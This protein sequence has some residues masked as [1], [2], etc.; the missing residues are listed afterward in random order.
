MPMC[1]IKQNVQKN[2]THKNWVCLNSGY[3]SYP[4]LLSF[5]NSYDT[6][7]LTMEN[8]NL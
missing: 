7:Q 5:T 8:V 3:K 4:H 2:K 6:T 1:K